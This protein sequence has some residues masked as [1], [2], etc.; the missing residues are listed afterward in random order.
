MSV[1]LST[2]TAPKN[3]SSV[4]I[5]H[6]AHN[7]AQIVDRLRPGTY[8]V[9]IIKDEIKSVDWNIEILRSELIQRVSLS[10]KN[11]VSE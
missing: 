5:S 2:S 7:L 4:D 10:N 1:A 9:T 11:Y 6:R 3:N 8:H